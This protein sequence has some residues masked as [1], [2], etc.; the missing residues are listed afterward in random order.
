[1]T[2]KP[3]NPFENPAV[4]DT[5]ETPPAT[6]SQ[7]ET[8]PGKV[9]IHKLEIDPDYKNKALERVHKIIE[10]N[11]YDLEKV[12][13]VNFDGEILH[14]PA[15]TTLTVTTKTSKKRMPGRMKGPIQVDNEQGL[16]IAVA[17]EYD[18]M[19]KDPDMIRKITETATA[20]E[21]RCFAQPNLVLQLPFWKK[22][23]VWF[24][25]C[26]SCRTTGKTKCQRCAGKGVDQC[27][28]CNGS[29]MCACTQC[30]G[31]QMIQGPQGRKV[32][33]PTCHGRGRMSC[34]L[35]NQSGRVQCPIC[36]TKGF[37]TC[38]VCQGNGWT[39]N[40]EIIEIEAKTSFTYPKEEL[41]EKIVALMEELGPK[42]TEHAQIQ[43]DLPED[44]PEKLKLEEENKTEEEKKRE[45]E[46]RGV[47]TIPIKYEVLLPYG[48]VEFDIGGQSYYAFMFGH[49]GTITHV[50]PFLEEIIQNGIR[51]LEDAVD[52]RGDVAENLRMA[53]EYRT[54][55]DVILCA[56]RLPLIKAIEKVKERNSLGIRDE[57]VNDLVVKADRAL[58]KITDK[59]RLLGLLAS[60]VSMA[61]LFGVYFIGPLRGMLDTRMPSEA[62]L[63]LCDFALLGIGIYL[64][65]VIMQGFASGA[66]KK[67]MAGIIPPGKEG[68]MTPKLGTK[69]FWAF[70]LIAAAFFISVETSRH[71]GAPV[72]GWYQ[73]VISKIIP[74]S[75]TKK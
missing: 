31:A 22:E 49:K 25:G 52:G 41:P 16:K 36:R 45:M 4:P 34:V 27:P 1:M 75:Q 3:E 30:R 69:G 5:P 23:F 2:D 66:I 65:T 39:S 40:L 37:T 33:C 62:A 24:E 35:C 56:A 47:F 61:A 43:I 8:A 20:R 29:G 26:G 50:S 44:D 72:P 38:P 55:K 28:R 13:L 46:N 64:T 58:K 7:P 18:K 67:A 17:K 11:K 68:K 48:H 63:G 71:T 57:T 32:Q 54:I 51:K 60:L 14:F 53:A 21:D 74:G 15:E 59:P 19:S 73:A 70:I 10:G 42:I 6:E 12:T 9:K